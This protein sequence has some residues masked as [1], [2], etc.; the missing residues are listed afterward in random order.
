MTISTN[1]KMIK[2]DSYNKGDILSFTRKERN[3]NVYYDISFISLSGID[4]INAMV[5]GT[6]LKFGNGVFLDIGDV[7]TINLKRCCVFDG[8][9]RHWFNPETRD[10]TKSSQLIVWNPK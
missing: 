2:I 10:F 4:L 5:I 3:K 8:T 6:Q 7:I 9:D 1:N